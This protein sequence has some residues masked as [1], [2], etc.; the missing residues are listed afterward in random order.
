[1]KH[2]HHIVPRCMGGTDDPSNLV[3]LTYEEH[4]DAH[5]IL[6]EQYPDHPGV[7]FAY[8]MMTNQSEEAMLKAA[9]MGGKLGIKKLTDEARS[10]GG[11]TNAAS[12][13]LSKI[14][15]IGNAAFINRFNS[16]LEFRERRIGVF[17]STA[18]KKSSCS[19]CGVETNL[20]NLK[21]WHNE[22]CR[23]KL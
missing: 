4:K 15:S 5:R 12:G 14:S 3:E 13:H 10:R 2:K 18:H 6:A 17:T 11:K 19:V 20:G 22:N 9:S 21:R 16:D 7:Q 1:M 8:L 23:R